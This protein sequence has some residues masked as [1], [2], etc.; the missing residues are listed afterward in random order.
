MEVR[1]QVRTVKVY[2]LLN[3]EDEEMLKAISRGNPNSEI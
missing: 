3:L 2:I 1:G